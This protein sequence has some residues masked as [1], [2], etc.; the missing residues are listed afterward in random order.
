M[1]IKPTLLFK[2]QWISVYKN[3]KNFF[4]CQRKG[5]NSI[6]ALLFR[7]NEN[8]EVEFMIHY[9]PMPEVEFKKSWDQPYPCTITGSFEDGDTAEETVIKEVAEEGGFIINKNH[10]V[11]SNINASSTQMNEMVFNY[12][13]D[14]TNLKQGVPTT[15]GSIFEQVA[16]NKWVDKKEIEKIIV[17]ELSLSSL[18]NCY[19]MYLI[20]YGN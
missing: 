13:I 9:Q 7:K 15:D 12:L 3:E 18:A 20:K 16:F 19:L 5:I 17:E 8:N 11:S 14:V 2:T 10:I 1:K 6:A 4:Y